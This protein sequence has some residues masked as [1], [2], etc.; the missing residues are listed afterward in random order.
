MD[1]LFY[2]LSALC[3]LVILFLL[4]LMFWQVLFV[5]IPRKEKGFKGD[6]KQRR[7][8][9]IIP[10]HN[11]ESVIANSLERLKNDLD[12]PKDL[13]DIF[14]CADNCTD[15]TFALAKEAGVIVYERH[16]DDP[17]KKRA[18]FPIQLLI[19]EVLNSEKG[20]DAIIKFDADNIP[21]KNFLEEMNRALGD[22]VEICRAHES[23]SNLGQNCWTQVAGVYW[24]EDRCRLG[25]K[26][27]H[28]AGFAN[29][30]F[31]LAAVVDRL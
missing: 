19:N 1:I 21:S 12:Y 8:A 23:S 11:E 25:S 5:F 30:I 7:F 14:V 28:F 27:A 15:S 20:Y 22:G 31:G 26:L 29:H 17:E 13:Y 9:I 2:V 6:G 24:H 10:A 16:E 3:G 4:F 18:A